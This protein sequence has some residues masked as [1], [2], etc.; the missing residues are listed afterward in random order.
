MEKLTWFHKNKVLL[1]GLISS[2]ALPLYYLINTG[3]TSIKV[4]VVATL[5]ALTSF[6]ARNLRGQVATISGIVG[7]I[8]ATYFTD[9]LD[10]PISWGQIILQAIVLYLAALTGPAKSV[11]YERTP[12]ILAATKEGERLVPTLASPKPTAL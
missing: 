1:I 6:L 5:A 10:H 9:A 4:I 8:L 11:G 2:I 7:T 3:E 12:E